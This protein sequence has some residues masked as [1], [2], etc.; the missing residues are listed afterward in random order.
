MCKNGPN[1]YF[2]LRGYF[3]CTE[4]Q[5]SLYFHMGV[6]RLAVQLQLSS[7][8][9]WRKQFQSWRNQFYDFI[10]KRDSQIFSEKYGQVC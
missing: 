8:K 3:L 5:V 7:L 1:R 9:P 4:A 6:I 10:V 2:F